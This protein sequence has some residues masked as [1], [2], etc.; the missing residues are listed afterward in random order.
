MCVCMCVCVCVYEHMCDYNVLL[1]ALDCALFQTRRGMC[2]GDGRHA[3]SSARPL[4]FL[5][6]ALS[7]AARTPNVRSAAPKCT[8]LKHT[9][10]APRGPNAE[11]REKSEGGERRREASFRGSRPLSPTAILF[12]ASAASLRRR[13]LALP[14]PPPPASADRLRAGAGGSVCRGGFPSFSIS[15]SLCLSLVRRCKGR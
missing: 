1:G 7:P 9:H 8:S 10:C 13:P 12:S 5:S 4:A 6:C 14:P 3:H 11:R 2:G 15:V